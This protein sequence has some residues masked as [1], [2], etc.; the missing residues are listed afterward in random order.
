MAHRHKNDNAGCETDMT[1]MIDV[2]FQLIIFFIVTM[3][4]DQDINPDIMLA[5]S[6]HGPA[7]EDEQPSTLVVEV[8]RKGNISIHNAQLSRAKFKKIMAS[9]RKRMGTFPVL[10]RGDKRARHEDIRAVMDICTDVGIWRINFAATKEDKT[11]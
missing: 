9:R 8:S 11:P 4:M 5:D 1:P 6:V 3:K 10:I 2:V 7:I